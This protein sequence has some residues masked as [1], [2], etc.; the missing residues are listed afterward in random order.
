MVPRTRVEIAEV[1]VFHLVHFREDLDAHQIRI[2]V[3]DRNVVADDVAT[4]AP[5]QL[6]LVVREVV[7]PSAFAQEKSTCYEP[8]ATNFHLG[9]AIPRDTGRLRRDDPTCSREYPITVYPCMV[10]P[11][12]TLIVWPVM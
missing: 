2:A 10:R 6:H 4:R 8:S 12:E 5:H 7:A 3:I 11:P 1:L 9:E